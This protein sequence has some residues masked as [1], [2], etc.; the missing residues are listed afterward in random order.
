MERY[1]DKRRDKFALLYLFWSWCLLNAD[2]KQ[3]TLHVSTFTVW[4]YSLNVWNKKVLHLNLIHIL[5]Q[6]LV[7]VERIVPEKSSNLCLGFMT[8]THQILTCPSTFRSRLELCTGMKSQ[9]AIFW[10][11]TSCSV[12]VGYWRFG[13]PCC[14]N[15]QPE[16]GVKDIMRSFIIRTQFSKSEM[17][18]ACSTPRKMR[19]ASKVCLKI[20]GDDTNKSEWHSWWNKRR[21]NP[22][23]A[24]YYSV[25]NFLS[26]RLI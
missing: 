3:H 5:W 6:V 21:L 15:F 1:L 14:F 2:T 4:N 9:L 11:V 22:G 7:F 25:Q 13:E 20:L 12:A 19:K 26:S 10:V 24:C 16:D 8:D 23:N 17:D 18:K